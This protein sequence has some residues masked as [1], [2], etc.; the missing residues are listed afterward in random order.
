MVT[1][2]PSAEIFGFRLSP[3]PSVPVLGRQAATVPSPVDA[4]VAV[5]I[6]PGPVAVQ[7]APKLEPVA[8]GS[9]DPAGGGVA[10]HAA[11]VHALLWL[12]AGRPQSVEVAMFTRLR[13]MLLVRLGRAA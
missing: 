5:R 4:P 2:R 13:S 7:V 12:A 1:K 8:A 6:R 3:L 11:S 9:G 10:V